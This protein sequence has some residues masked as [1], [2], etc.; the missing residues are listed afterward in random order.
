MA[1]APRVLLAGRDLDALPDLAPPTCLLVTF[2]GAAFDLPILERAFPGWRRP[3]AHVDL[4]PVLERLGHRGG[5]KAIE[6]Q[7][8]LGRPP[9]CAGWTAAGP[10]GCGGTGRAA[11]ARRCGCSPSTTSTTPSTCAP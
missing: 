6:E 1:T 4:R 2:N 7:T 8:G 10:A 3:A 5:L 9:T 11:T